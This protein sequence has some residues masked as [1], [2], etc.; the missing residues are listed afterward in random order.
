MSE[1]T[2]VPSTSSKERASVKSVIC[3]AEGSA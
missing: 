3:V 2:N 1:E